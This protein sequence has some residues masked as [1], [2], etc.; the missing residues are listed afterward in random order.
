MLRVA[1]GQMLPVWTNET[2]SFKID[3]NIHQ[4][5]L[6]IYAYKN[7]CDND[8]IVD[9]SGRF[10]HVRNDVIVNGFSTSLSITFAYSDSNHISNTS[11]PIE[12]L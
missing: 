9:T 3:K 8:P 6:E 7:R 11:H 2:K 1:T 12:L 4:K 10:A 5:F